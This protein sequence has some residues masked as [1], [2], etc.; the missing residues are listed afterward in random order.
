MRFSRKQVTDFNLMISKNYKWKKIKCSKRIW[1][2]GEEMAG[3]G[4]KGNER[5]KERERGKEREKE[6]R[7]E[8]G[9]IDFPPADSLHKFLQHPDLTE[10]SYF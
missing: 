7:T 8:E 6:S 9:E 2:E 4:E 1:W 3:E 5:Q 10:E